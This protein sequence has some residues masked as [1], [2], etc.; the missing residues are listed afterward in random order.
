MVD[1]PQILRQKYDMDFTELTG[2]STTGYAMGID[3]SGKTILAMA[4]MSESAYS[5]TLPVDFW[6]AAAG[7]NLLDQ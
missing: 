1:L 7:V 3:D 4:Q 2:W 5:L 6:E